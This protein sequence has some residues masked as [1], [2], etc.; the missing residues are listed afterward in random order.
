RVLPERLYR[1]ARAVA[2][3]AAG[4]ASDVLRLAIP[5]RMVRAEKAW[6]QRPRD[7]EEPGKEPAAPPEELEAYPG[8]A[9]RLRAGERVAVDAPPRP[10][11]W[12]RLLAAAASDALAL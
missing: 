11:A 6:L 8:L 2:D 4:S 7:A 5:K 10:D 3:R 9:D 1:V 12:A